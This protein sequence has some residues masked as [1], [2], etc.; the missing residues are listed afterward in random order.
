VVYAGPRQHRTF[1]PPPEWN[2]LAPATDPAHPTEV[3]AGPWDVAVFEN[4][5]PAFGTTPDYGP[6]SEI[7]ETAPGHGRC[8]VV[9]YAQD[10]HASLATLPLEHLELIVAVW[11]DRT[12]DLGRREDVQYVFPFE[13]R[14]LEVGVTLHHPHGQIYAY[15]FVPPVVARQL[16]L[17]RI[18]QEERRRGLVD[19]LIRA[20]LE[21]DIR[22]LFVSPHALAWIPVCARWAYEVW[23]APRRAAP[24][25][26]DLTDAERQDV[27]RALQVAVRKLDGLWGQPMPYVLGVYQAPP[28]GAHDYAHV[29]IEILPWLRMKGRLKY[30]A[31]SEVAAGVFTADTLPE[32]KARELRAVE[33]AHD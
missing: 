11:A 24:M 5:F 12:R 28:R 32:D 6:P 17:Q 8:E 18:H 23:I 9:V 16:E 33:V 1:L 31:G 7:V 25:L 20:E 30:L 26:S 19:A 29:H 21:A 2:P 22:T 27:A 4:L 13:N 10:P 3:P 14:G 15:P